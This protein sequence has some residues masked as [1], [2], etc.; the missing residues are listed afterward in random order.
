MTASSTLRLVHHGGPF[1]AAA[2]AVGFGCSDVVSVGSKKN[3]VMLYSP[4]DGPPSLGD[5]STRGKEDTGEGRKLHLLRPGLNTPHAAASGVPSI[6]VLL[7]ERLRGGWSIGASSQMQHSLPSRSLWQN[8]LATISGLDP[9]HEVATGLTANPVLSLATCSVNKNDPK[10]ALAHFFSDQKRAFTHQEASTSG[11]GLELGSGVG[12]QTPV[13]SF[14]SWHLPVP[15]SFFGADSSP[16]TATSPSKPPLVVVIL[17]WLGSKQ[18]HLKK[19]ADWYTE[20]GIHCVTFTIPMSSVLSVGKGGKAEEHIDELVSEIKRW[21]V[22][23]NQG[24]GGEEHA[25]MF[26]TFSNTG[27]LMYGAVLERLHQEGSG[28]L[29]KIKGCVVDSAPVVDPD[30]QVGWQGLLVLDMSSMTV[31]RKLCWPIC[32]TCTL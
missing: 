26:H 22:E 23:I 20:Q 4:L 31:C 29:G 5:R 21:V 30:P 1:A 15:G 12:S 27:W 13:F 28:L 7:T 25:V 18:K 11:S 3:A 32:P 2:F 10:P 24:D 9:R 16:P 17:G 14:H 19:Y 6:D 8:K